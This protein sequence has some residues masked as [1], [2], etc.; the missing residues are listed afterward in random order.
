M[1]VVGFSFIRNAVKFDYPIVESITSILPIC[2]EFIIALGNSDD[3]TED[4]IKSIDSN[5]IRIIHTTWDDSLRKGGKVL[6]VETNKAFNQIKEADWAFYIQGDEVIHEKYLPII[7]ESMEKWKDD[8]KV[9]GLLL[10]YTHFYGSYDFVGDSRR[11]YRREIRI[12]RADKNISSFRDA[13]GFRKNDRKLNVKHIDAWVY[14]YGWVKPPF[15]QQEKQKYF[16][17]LWHDEEWIKKNV[18]Q[19]NQFDYS[20]IDSLSIFEG[21][22][23]KVMQERIN[24]LNWKFDFDPT[25][26]NF[27]LKTKLLHWVEKKSGWR[28]GEYKN[29]KII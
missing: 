29:Y 17:S 10:N 12:V 11:W 16:N 28:I 26:K 24:K 22:H 2:D 18:K 27:G 15:E 7:K 8:Q 4:L 5:K 1:K 19:T 3:N 20:T 23:P 21:T 14:H 9:E 13:Q 25:K 6:A